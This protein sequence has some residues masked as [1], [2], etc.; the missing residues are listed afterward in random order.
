MMDRK[1]GDDRVEL[2]KRRKWKI[3]IVRDDGYLGIS[4]EEFRK[5]LHHGGREIERDEAGVRASS[6]HQCEEPTAAAAQVNHTIRTH[7]QEFKKSS[8]AFHAVR[9][10]IGAP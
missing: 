5:R 9:D 1:A 7:R 10:R 6:F 8:F 3:E 2:T 4:R